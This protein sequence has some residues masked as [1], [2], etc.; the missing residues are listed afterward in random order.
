MTAKFAPRDAAPEKVVMNDAGKQFEITVRLPWEARAN[1]R[2][3]KTIEWCN[4]H[5]QGVK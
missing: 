4:A 5:Q 3:Q 2:I 1:D